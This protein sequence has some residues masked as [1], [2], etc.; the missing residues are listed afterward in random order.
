MKSGEYGNRQWNLN[1]FE[2]GFYTLTAVANGKDLEINPNNK[3]HVMMFSP[4]AALS[5]DILSR[6]MFGA[7][8]SLGIGFIVVV[9]TG[10]A[11]AFIGAVSGYFSRL[12]QPLM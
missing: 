1:D 6:V 5:R 3:D 8:A 9:V 12:D 2:T 10:F 4:C 11:G 7:R